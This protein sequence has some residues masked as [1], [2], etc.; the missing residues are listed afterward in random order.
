MHFQYILFLITRENDYIAYSEMRNF[1]YYYILDVLYT[2]WT[3]N[4]QVID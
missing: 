3:V 1:I 2:K 4:D